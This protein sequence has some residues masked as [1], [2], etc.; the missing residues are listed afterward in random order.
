MTGSFFPHL[1]SPVSPFFQA[2]VHRS[3]GVYRR[4]ASQ[5]EADLSRGPVIWQP[6][7]KLAAWPA[8]FSSLLL[9]SPR[10]A[11]LAS[12]REGDS[13]RKESGQG[14]EREVCARVCVR[15]LVLQQNEGTDRRKESPLRSNTRKSQNESKQLKKRENGHRFPS[16]K[17]A[18]EAGSEA[19]SFS[20]SS[21]PLAGKQTSLQTSTQVSCLFVCLFPCFP[22][23]F[24]LSVLFCS[25]LF[26]SIILRTPQ[27]F[28]GQVSENSRSRARKGK[29]RL[30]RVG[31]RRALR[32]PPSPGACSR[33]RCVRPL[34]EAAARELA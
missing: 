13:A 15:A 27:S 31:W 33:I 18:K 19:R 12:R 9:P 8:P 23:F 24:S 22:C 32:R 14:A 4:Q 16:P 10:G 2:L 11:S 1:P 30:R 34:V 3:I 21:S 20:L 28:A 17:G 7:S 29:E 25:V 26:C 5:P 6:R